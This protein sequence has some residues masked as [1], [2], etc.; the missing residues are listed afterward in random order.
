M[1]FVAFPYRLRA[2]WPEVS[3]VKAHPPSHRPV[4]RSPAPIAWAGTD[5]SGGIA[6]R[7]W[8]GT[9]RHGATGHWG[10]CGRRLDAPRR[11]HGLVHA[12]RV[13]GLSAL[14]G[15]SDL[16]HRLTAGLADPRRKNGS[17]R[18]AGEFLDAAVATI[19]DALAALVRPS[20]P[21]LDTALENSL[22][23]IPDGSSEDAGFLA[24]VRR[25]RAIHERALATGDRDQGRRHRQ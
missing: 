1:A 21:A 5:T 7:P 17:V 14:P 22:A 9:R 4:G 8:P 25:A 12:D 23:S 15:R 6:A 18:S 2:A 13:D 19:H 10:A 20:K 16:G 11:G 24:T 3:P